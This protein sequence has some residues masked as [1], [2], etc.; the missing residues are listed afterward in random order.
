M[1]KPQACVEFFSP[2]EVPRIIM[3]CS[4]ALPNRPPV[5]IFSHKPKAFPLFDILWASKSKEDTA[6]GLPEEN[7]GVRFRLALGTV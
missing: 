5:G 7:P 1:E 3:L 2:R 4:G 6:Q